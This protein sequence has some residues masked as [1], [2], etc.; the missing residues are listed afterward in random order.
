MLFR[1][2]CY[3]AN[4]LEALQGG[5][6]PKNGI[7]ARGSVCQGGKVKSLFCNWSQDVVHVLEALTDDLEKCPIKASP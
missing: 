3:L 2:I 5:I 1:S 4:Q 6:S 7:K